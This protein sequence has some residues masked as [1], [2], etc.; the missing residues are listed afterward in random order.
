MK[1]P[2]S[3]Y[4]VYAVEVKV[5]LILQTTLIP[6]K[7]THH[8]PQSLSSNRLWKWR[9]WNGQCHRDKW[10]EAE[11][12]KGLEWMLHYMLCFFAWGLDLSIYSNLLSGEQT[13]LPTHTKIIDSHT[14]GTFKPRHH[15]TTHLWSKHAER[16]FNNLSSTIWWSSTCVIIHL[17][18]FFL[19]L[20]HLTYLVPSPTVL[21]EINEMRTAMFPGH[22]N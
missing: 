9:I 15:R 2:Q 6:Y 21:E 14:G 10:E 18:S 12:R 3:W 17:Y 11:N 16:L 22:F 13:H 8:Q 5:M 20:P 4:K 1:K 19:L 7:H